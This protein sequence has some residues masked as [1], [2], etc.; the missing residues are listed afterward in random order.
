LRVAAA[1][2]SMF[3]GTQRGFENFIFSSYGTRTPRSR[4]LRPNNLGGR[5]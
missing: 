3:T 1:T 2:L 4:R 5:I